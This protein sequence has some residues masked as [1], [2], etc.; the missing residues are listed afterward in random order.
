[1]EEG[2]GRS[3]SWPGVEEG[4]GGVGGA[5]CVWM[6]QGECY[7]QVRLFESGRIALPYFSQMTFSA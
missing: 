4:P 7:G 3:G 5:V 1:M 2:G 6:A